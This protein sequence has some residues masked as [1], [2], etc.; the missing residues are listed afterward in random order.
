MSAETDRE[1]SAA[2]L[3]VVALARYVEDGALVHVGTSTFLGQVAA[4]FAKATHAP[5]ATVM[6]SSGSGYFTGPLVVTLSLYEAMTLMGGTAERTTDTYT[7]VER[8]ESCGFEPVIPVQIDAYGNVNLS[9]IGKDWARPKIRLPGSAGL[10]TLPCQTH[11]KLRFYT[12]RHNTRTFVPKVDF[13]TAAGYLTGPGA[14]EAAG[15]SG[16]GGPGSI[17]TNL[18]V[19]DWED[20]SRRMRVVSLHPGVTAEQVR[21]NTG[22][23]VLGL[24]R[25][26]PSTPTPGAADIALIR[27]I[28]PFGIRR[29]EFL[30]GPERRRV[31]HEVLDAEEALV[32]RRPDDGYRVLSFRS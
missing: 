25:C 7:H 5:K 18:G 20:P 13:I 17:V 27:R 15:F 1:T 28:D 8:N 29:L 26:P 16:D 9:M 19:F 23:E 21:A 3:M 30:E 32:D 14:R 4:I 10:D 24:D 2:D 12:T 22:F 6:A 31:L 11:A